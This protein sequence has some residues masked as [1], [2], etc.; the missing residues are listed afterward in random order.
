[1]NKLKNYMNMGISKFIILVSFVN[2]IIYN[3]PLFMYSFKH[4]NIFSLSG[5]LTFCSVLILLF[6]ITSFILFLF[7]LISIKLVKYFTMFMIFAN[8]IALYFVTTYQVVL[9][10]TMMGNVFNTD[11]AE[12]TSYFGIKMLIY[13]LFLGVIPSFIIYKIKIQKQKK[14]KLFLNTI[15]ILVSGVFLMYL[16]SSTWLWLDKNFRILGGLAMPWSYIINSIRYQI[17]KYKQTKKQIL[18]PSSI[19]RDNKKMVVVLVIGESARAKNFS[20][21]G[22]KRN[23]NPNLK[24]VKNLVV[25]KAKSLAT[26]TTASV[27]S[28]LSYKGST[29]DN[30]EVL[31]NYL[32]RLGIHVIWRK[33]NWGAPTLHIDKIET[34]SDLTRFCKEKNCNYDEGLLTNLNKEILSS[35]KNK[36]FVVLH[37]AGSHGPTYY[38]KYPKSFEIFKPVCKT[39]DL[40]K[41]THQELINAYDNTILYTDYFL[42]KTIQTL[43]KIKDRPVV[44]IYLS[45]HGESLGEY[46]LYL[47]GTPYYIAPNYQKDVP[48]LIWMS[49][50]FLKQKNLKIEKINKNK[51][52]SSK[53]IFHTVLGVFNMNSDI[54]N[55]NLDILNVKKG[56]E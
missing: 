26:Y 18:L 47:H 14:S 8:S 38:K 21:Y 7:A 56:S 6:V 40:K 44:M 29:S 30:Y 22:Y 19:F 1:M 20:L 53:N 42:F 43:K 12:A 37:T 17:K 4:L 35:N 25:L 2:M 11:T 39:V 16:N 5:I 27:H 41:C 9:D 51:I 32:N 36:V 52:Y 28:M 23:T 3:I 45:D 33:H 15:V 46:G 31:P 48:F 49:D 50:M 13:I 34:L 55:K 10:R 54:Y 24:K